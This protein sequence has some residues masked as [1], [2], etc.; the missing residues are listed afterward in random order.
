MN[1]FPSIS[2]RNPHSKRVSF[3]SGTRSIFATRVMLAVAFLMSVQ[4]CSGQVKSATILSAKTGKSQLL[5]A[6][7]SS[8]APKAKP[9]AHVAASSATVA[10]LVITAYNVDGTNS[11]TA[12]LGRN[13]TLDVVA[14]GQTNPSYTWSVQGAGTI[15]SAGVYTAPAAMPTNNSVTVTSTL[16]S[17]TSL[18]ASYTMKL[19]YS[20]PTIMWVTPSTLLSGETNTVAI[21]GYDFTPAT[22]IT[23]GGV[24]VPAVFNGTNGVTAQIPVAANVTSAL[25][26]VASNPTPGGGGST[27]VS[28][29]VKL[30]TM[31]LN[32][33][34]GDGTNSGTARLGHNVDLQASVAGM[35]SPGITWSVQG[36][37]TITS[38]GIYAAPASMPS[39]GTVKII[40]ALSTNASVVASYTLSLL[41]T[42]PTVD[43]VI[44]ATLNSGQTNSVQ[45]GGLDFTPATT[46]KVGGVVVPTVFQA[47]NQV[48]AQ[49]SI[50]SGST[51]A[52]SIIASNPTPGGGNGA[53]VSAAVQVPSMTLTAYNVDG[54]NTGTAR[55]NR[56]VTVD[57][58][59]AG[60]AHPGVTWSVQ[61][62]GT[63]TT[64]GVYTAPAVM[65]S[66]GNVTITA[67]LSTNAT[68]TASYSL[69]LVYSAP[70]IRWV[71]PASLVSGAMNSV[72]I[73][74]DD[75]T[76]STTLTVNGAAVP[77]TFNGTNGVTAQIPI[78]AGS[79]TAL[80]VIATNPAPGGGSSAT[81]SAPVKPLAITVSSY[82][83]TSVNASTTSLGQSVQFVSVV[84]GGSSAISWPVTWSVQGAG[85]ISAAGLYQ[86]PTGVPASSGVVVTAT[87]VSNPS[88]TGSVSLTLT[89]P[90]PIVNQSQPVQAT[91]GAT[92]TFTF[93]GQNFNSSTSIQ[94]N[95]QAVST[96]YL[97]TTSVSAAITTAQS[98][99]GALLITATNRTP[100]G[101]QS[102]VFLLSIGSATSVQAT[103]GSTPG[104]AIPG[105][106]VGFSHEWG[107]AQNYMGTAQTGVNNIYR[108]LVQNLTNPG[109]SFFIRI[110]GGSTDNTIEPTA[111]TV[112]AFSDLAKAMPVHFTL[113]VNLA[114][115]NLKLS[116]D[117]ASNY[118]SNMPAGSLVALELGN[119]ADNY[120]NSGQRASTY[121]FTDYMSDFNK[122]STAIAPLVPSTLKY[123]GPS[124]TT[125][126]KLQENLPALEPAEATEMPV[127]SAHFYGGYFENAT[128]IPTQFPADYLLEPATSQ[129]SVQG[130]GVIAAAAHK[131][132]DTFRIG[133][134][135]SIDDSG[136]RGISDTFSSAMWAVDAMFEQ[137]NVGVDGVNF[138]GMSGCAYCAFTFGTQQENGKN[139]YRLQQVNPLYYGMLFFHDATV[140][141]AKLLPVTLATTNVNVKVWATVDAAGTVRVAILNKDEA[142]TGNVSITVPGYGQATAIRMV[143]PNYKSES[144]IA[145]GGQTF[146]NSFD[147]NLIGAAMSEG[148]S[149]TNAVYT[150]PVQPTSAVLLT[151]TK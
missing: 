89:N 38:G 129:R 151:L 40:A 22:T 140:N 27:V 91:A 118:A 98:A 103:I 143:A 81:A 2:P 7:E 28:A 53:A 147:G 66:N 105:D 44:P 61:G 21:S 77:T 104:R 128:G 122:W 9:V 90:S 117:Q 52:V 15:T 78:A 65:P 14:P 37:G 33:Y 112:T 127:L 13:V 149:P 121:D 95:G 59:I 69:R 18:T 79:T 60:N 47:P 49:I 116:E 26:L 8:P 31:T 1:A 12:R 70:N 72:Q 93:Y 57:A 96:T 142:F 68:V 71:V 36:A 144:G 138:H 55:L 99:T 111:T 45:I 25:S 110:G 80:A 50:A 11:G 132:G 141:S 100:N 106:F 115:N 136:V 6:I 130:L 86:A 148:F 73:G 34:S 24:S 109:T 56:N 74:G 32:A 3:Q 43:W 17:N 20:A 102:A 46:I 107:E 54:T 126:W 124:F 83:T 94:V 88:V 35:T 63:I 145:I 10:G 39:N 23:V 133:E 85:T 41:Y 119:E 135:N 92:N 51:S 123:M 131:N 146:D 75:F 19:I 76:A 67:Q 64:A 29:A 82:S 120:N 30:P 4:I 84:S 48:V 113:G 42:A 108:Q 5:P 87:L 137:A 58:A 97:S 139:T 16:V 134:M 114:S 101:G 62:A 125:V 150:I